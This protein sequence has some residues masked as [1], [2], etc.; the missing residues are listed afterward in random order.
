MNMDMF[1]DFCILSGCDYCETINQVGPITSFNSIIKYKNIETYIKTLKE[2]D[3][4][5]LNY[6]SARKIFKEFNYDT[7]PKEDLTK[8]N[9]NQSELLEFLRS[10]DFKQNVISKFLKILN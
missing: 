4:F 7:I 9:F 1:V 10:K 2:H 3:Y 8:K 5:N 6:E